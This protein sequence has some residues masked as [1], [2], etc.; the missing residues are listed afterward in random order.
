MN[1]DGHPQTLQAAQ[2]G[3]KNAVRNGI[4]SRDGRALQ[5]QVQELAE[6]IMAL[7]HTVPMD[8]VGAVEIAKLT[9]LIEAMDDD[10]AERG[11]TKKR[12]GEPRGLIDLRLRASR[13]LAEWLD[14]YGLTPQGRA[15][16]ASTMAQGGLAAEIA[17]RREQARAATEVTTDG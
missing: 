5:P 8:Y 10:L 3:N 7:P 14:R 4:W 17:R 6:Q 11:L 16:W 9:V 15:S 2:P 13:R 12:G 1:T